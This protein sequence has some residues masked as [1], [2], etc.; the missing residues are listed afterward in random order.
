MVQIRKSSILKR[1]NDK[2]N[3]DPGIGQGG[4]WL[5]PFV[6][7]NL[8]IEPLLAELKSTLGTL[9]VSGGATVEWLT[10]PDGKRWTILQ[11]VKAATA[12]GG[13]IV[14]VNPAGTQVM[15]LFAAAAIM[16]PFTNHIVITEGWKIKA[17]PTG[18]V[19]DTAI[20]YESL[21]LETDAF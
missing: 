10:V 4:L 15:S 21:Y 3:L 11:L 9:D 14:L 12:S 1:I 2:L 16:T 8:D 17:G 18:N 19:G 6:V 7:I 13:N 5:S 20:R